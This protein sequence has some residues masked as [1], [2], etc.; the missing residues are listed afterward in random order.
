MKQV[1]TAVRSAAPPCWS[2][3]PAQRAFAHRAGR[4]EVRLAQSADEIRQAQQLRYHALLKDLPSHSKLDADD[5]DEI[6]AH[7]VVFEDQ[8]EGEPRLVGNLRL[9]GTDQLLPNQLL[10]TEQ[11][12]HLDALR[13]QRGKLLEL[14]RFCIAE[15]ARSGTV[16][17]LIWNYTIRYIMEHQYKTMVGCASFAGTNIQ[18][19]REVLTYLYQNNLAPENL[20]PQPTDQ[21][22]SIHLQQFV[23]MDQTAGDWQIAKKSVPTLLRGY[24]KMGAKISDQAIIDP[25]FNTTFVC[26]YVDAKDMVKTNPRLQN[27][28]TY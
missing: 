12:F 7:V 2:D 23:S 27:Q 10:Y 16:L 5:L 8:P 26:I 3:S 20:Q 14:S 28:R 21:V 13:K 24:L 11:S 9:V 6:A 15:G 17:M 4:F 1:N 19:H 25:V 18:D 22:Q